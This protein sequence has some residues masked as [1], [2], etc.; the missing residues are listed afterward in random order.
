MQ[1]QLAD[2]GGTGEG[3]L[4]DVRMGGKSRAGSF[5][6]SRDD[7]DHSIRESG[8]LNQLAE[9]QRGKR[10][11]FGRLQ[12]AG[13]AHRESRAEL[14]GC[15]YEREIPGNN[16]AYHADWL[17]YRIGVKFRRR[18]K[19]ERYRVAFNLRGPSGVIAHVFDRDRNIG[20]AGDAE[21]LAIVEGFQLGEFFEVLFDQISELPDQVAALCR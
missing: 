15:H 3:Y 14:P 21:R 13:A 10:S 19:N 6:V 7:V 18:G 11:L 5:A 8:F 12:D 1:N 20:S 9:T 16:L 4:V 17:P 2:F